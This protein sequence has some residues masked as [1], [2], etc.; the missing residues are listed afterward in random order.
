MT[1]SRTDLFEPKNVPR[2]VLPYLFT[3]QRR[4]PMIEIDTTDGP[5]TY[6]LPNAG[7]D[8]GNTGQSNQNAEYT[9]VKTSADANAV[10]ITGA[11]GGDVSLT[12]SG[13]VARFKSNGTSWIR[14][15]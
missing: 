8:A 3:L 9:V 10:T 4:Q 7:L 5:E 2:E 1:V 13:Q 12:T 6:P 11:S 15:Q 14:L